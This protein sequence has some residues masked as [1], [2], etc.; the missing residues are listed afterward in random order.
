MPSRL[1]EL[2]EQTISAFTN[3][4]YFVLTSVIV[5]SCNRCHSYHLTITPRHLV[6]LLIQGLEH[7]TPNKPPV[8]SDHIGRLPQE[9][10]CHIF[11]F[12]ELFELLSIAAGRTCVRNDSWRWWS[13]FIGGVKTEGS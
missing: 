11:S 8:E 7:R 10:L 5:C 13:S 12:L 2:H 9:L 1:D 6:C 3:R 4:I